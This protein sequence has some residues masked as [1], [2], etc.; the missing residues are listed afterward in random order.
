MR[1]FPHAG[2]DDFPWLILE[3]PQA[4]QHSSMMSSYDLKT[5][6]ESQRPRTNI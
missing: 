4:W 5:Q 1:P 3:L 2:G 6:F